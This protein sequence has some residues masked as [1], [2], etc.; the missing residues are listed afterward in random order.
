MVSILIPTY[1]YNIVNLVKQ[2][3]NQSVDSSITFEIIVVDDCSTSLNIKKDNKQINEFEF[4]KLV[5][6][7]Q[8]LGRTATRNLLA[9]EAKYDWL[10][11]LDADVLPKYNDFIWR[12]HFSEGSFN[13]YIIIL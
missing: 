4:C 3:Y 6:N 10:L 9:S 13:H 11:F 12:F 7:S 2:I 5:E 8:N 1:N